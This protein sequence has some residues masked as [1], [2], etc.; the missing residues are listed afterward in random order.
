MTTVY[1]RS[2]ISTSAFM[3]V[4]YYENKKPQTPAVVNFPENFQTTPTM[5]VLSF[6]SD[7]KEWKAIVSVN[8]LKFTTKYFNM[9]S[10]KGP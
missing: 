3:F 10:G 8:V 2:T 6:I 7:L 9:C 4:L 1:F 5:A